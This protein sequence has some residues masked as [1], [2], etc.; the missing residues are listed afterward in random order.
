MVCHDVVTSDFKR[1]QTYLES[2][3]HVL[4]AGYA[5]HLAIASRLG[6][7]IATNDRKLQEVTKTL[8]FEFA[9]PAE[10]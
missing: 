10:L 4:R 2:G 5:M 7:A 8:Q 1:A 9:A 6:L 3:H